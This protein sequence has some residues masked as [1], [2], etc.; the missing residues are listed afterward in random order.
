MVPAMQ[1]MTPNEHVE[2][3]YCLFVYFVEEGDVRRDD[4]G[5]R[6]ASAQWVERMDLDERCDLL[7]LHTLLRA[8]CV[9]LLAARLAPHL[10]EISSGGAFALDRDAAEAARYIVSRLGLLGLDDASIVAA[11]LCGYV[12]QLPT[13][14]VVCLLDSDT[15]IRSACV[16]RLVEGLSA[17]LAELGRGQ[18]LDELA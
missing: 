14:R 4:E 13:R 17:N 9:D 16:D 15:L 6:H 12:D 18:R 3:A 11:E 8:A 7:D 5:L 2:A 1:R 10:G